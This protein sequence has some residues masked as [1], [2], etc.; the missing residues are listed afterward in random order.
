[1]KK[2]SIA[3]M[4]A[5]CAMTSISASTQQPAQ[6]SPRTV[7]AYGALRDR[8]SV[9]NDAPWMCRLVTVTPTEKP[10]RDV[11]SITITDLA[12][13]ETLSA[14][15]KRT[16]E[17]NP[18]HLAS[19]KEDDKSSILQI[20]V[21][22]LYY[23]SGNERNDYIGA[24]AGIFSVSGGKAEY[25]SAGQMTFAE[26]DI[27]FAD[28]AAPSAPKIQPVPGEKGGVVPY[29]DVDG[30]SIQIFIWNSA[31]PAYITAN[32]GDEGTLRLG[33]IKVYAGWSPT[34][35]TISAIAPD[36]TTK[37]WMG[38]FK[39]RNSYGTYAQIFILDMSDLR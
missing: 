20:P 13:G 8:L 33:A 23:Q 39:N 12:P 19:V 2:I 11:R 7:S 34:R 35:V 27:R 38:D 17:F 4:L 18:F 16:R 9:K 28:D 6:V 5:L 3:A 31:V 29:L 10:A 1:M 32:G 22:A 15:K 25:P 21:I 24:A 30:T 14:D 36:G 26:K 37:S